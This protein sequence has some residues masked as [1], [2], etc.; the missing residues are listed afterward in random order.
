MR[1]SGYVTVCGDQI[2]HK[3]CIETGRRSNLI[4]LRDA[5]RE[6][7]FALTAKLSMSTG[8][9]ARSLVA[10]TK[11]LA[12]SVDAIQIPDSPFSRPHICSLATAALVLN[13]GID[14]IVHINCRDRNRIAVQSDILGAQTLGVSNV[15]MKLGTKLPPDHRPATSNVFDFNTLDLL[16]TAAAI[17]DSEALAAGR[18]PGAPELHIGSVAT[19]FQPTEKWQPDKL[20]AKADAGAQFVQLQVCMA[21]DVLRDYAAKIV[22]S[23]LTW[24][25]QILAALAVF[26]SAESARE[27]KKARRLSIVPPEVIDRLDKSANPVQEGIDICAETLAELAKIPGISGASLA[28]GGDPESIVAAIEKS[29]IRNG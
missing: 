24:R 27:L 29:G 1:S 4:T 7:D 22:E 21:P 17:R 20:A 15:L 10:E 13:E 18:L 3:R 23:K 8:L 2:D 9:S 6:K 16:R 14:P 19:A 12:S 5:I 26:P 28:T 11:V 25:L